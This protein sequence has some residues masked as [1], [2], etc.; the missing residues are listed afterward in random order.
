MHAQQRHR[1]LRMPSTALVIPASADRCGDSRE[2]L[3]LFGSAL[4]CRRFTGF[5]RSLGRR[6]SA[7]PTG[8]V[9][10]SLQKKQKIIAG[11]LRPSTNTSTISPTVTSLSLPTEMVLQH[12]PRRCRRDN[13]NSIIDQAALRPRLTEPAM[14]LFRFQTPGIPRRHHQTRVA[15]FARP[16]LLDQSLAHAEF[17]GRD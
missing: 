6:A 9:A 13:T 17:G 14:Q 2:R 1:P 4:T 15:G 8:R 11:L 12:K 16:M 3:A 10:D 7:P 5:A